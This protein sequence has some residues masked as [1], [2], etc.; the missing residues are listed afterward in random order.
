MQYNGG[1]HACAKEIAGIIQRECSP[2]RYWE[3]FVGAA[4]VI[5]RPE[6]GAFER[7]GSDIDEGIVSLLRAVRDGWTPP[8]YISEDAYAEARCGG[9]CDPAMRAF[10]GYGCSFGGKYFGGYARSGDRNYAK[11]AH[12]SLLR[13]AGALVGVSLVAAPYD[14][15]PF[16]KVDVVYCDPPY[17]GTTACGAGGAFDSEAFWHWCE[18]LAA[19]GTRVFVSEFSAPN[20]W[21]EVWQKELRDGLRK[22]GASHSMTERLFTI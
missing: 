22:S 17:A 9:P 20:G 6:L 8:D 21:V 13:Q 11:N 1:K 14:A 4:N 18:G 16:G 19:A 12:N 5:C 2:G 7:L 3:P 15:A 10:I